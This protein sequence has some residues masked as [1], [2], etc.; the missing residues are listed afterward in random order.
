[1][2]DW[3]TELEKI[4][5]SDWP[6]PDPLRDIDHNGIVLY[7]AGAMG[8]M[9]LDFL[10]LASISPRYIVDRK[11]AGT[12]DGVSV[13][14]PEQIPVG[15]RTKFT[16][17]ICVATSPM[18]PIVDYLKCLGCK[19][20]RHFYD[21]TE[22][23]PS[24]QMGNG[25]AV[26]S[27]DPNQMEGIRTVCSALSHDQYSLAHYLQFL[28]WRLRR[29]EVLFP[30]YPVLCNQKYFKVPGYPLLH[31]HERFVDGGAHY[32]QNIAAFLE[33][34]QGKFDHIWAFE[35]DSDNFTVLQQTVAMYAPDVTA[36]I[37]L[38][39]EALSANVGVANFRNGLN[40]ASRIDS[41][42]NKQIQTV[43]LDSMPEIYPTIIR[44]H[45]E[46]QELSTLRGAEKTICQHQPI[47]MIIADHNSDGLY[48]IGEFILGHKN[49]QLHFH[50]HDFCGNTAVFYAVPYPSK[51]RS[52]TDA[53]TI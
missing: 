18:N 3:E 35:P 15:D 38:R 43:S 13:I 4:L 7:G 2:M 19:D 9:A 36:R 53:T 10:K 40:F 31:D 51:P 49:Y 33:A 26:K 14:T 44:L 25:W 23:I 52:Q 29:K 11:E 16:F 20:I 21:C 47:L 41:N 48:K 39:N 28:W 34:V 5:A 24:M 1:M 42:G 37:F 12:L 8:R 27:P 32:G 45:I 6:T 30:D 17:V 22:V 46:G 50:L